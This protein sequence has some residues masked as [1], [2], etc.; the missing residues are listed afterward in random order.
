MKIVF[1]RY[2]V[3]AFE[4]SQHVHSLFYSALF[5]EGRV[6]VAYLL[7]DLC[8]DS[9]GLH[10]KC[11]TASILPFIRGDAT[12]CAAGWIF[13]D[14]LK[15]CYYQSHQRELFLSDS[16]CHLS[17]CMCVYVCVCV[18]NGGVGDEAGFV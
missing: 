5:V 9:V 6:L 18:C 8:G 15:C 2:S 16:V 10:Y 14:L 3:G 4:V 1:S 17:L 7:L 13:L 12:V 11:E